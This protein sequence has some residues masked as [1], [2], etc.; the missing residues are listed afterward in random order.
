MGLGMNEWTCVWLGHIKLAI[1]YESLA[2]ENE[3]V[4]LTCLKLF[5]SDLFL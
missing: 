3:W 1:E 5:V 4:V 2:E